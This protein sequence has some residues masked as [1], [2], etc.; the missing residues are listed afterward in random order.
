MKDQM[1]HPQTE[2]TNK[3]PMYHSISDE[4]KAKHPVLDAFTGCSLTQEDA[5]ELDRLKAE[6]LTEE[7]TDER[8]L[9]LATMFKEQYDALCDKFGD[10]DM[11]Y[12][13]LEELIGCSQA[14]IITKQCYLLGWT[15]LH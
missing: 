2:G 7:V 5:A 1:N 6:G 15:T 3:T 11:L 8:T 9:A 10:D 4:A 12:E 13:D 14:D